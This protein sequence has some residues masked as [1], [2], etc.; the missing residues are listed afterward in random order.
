MGVQLFPLGEKAVLGHL[1]L[2]DLL[3]ILLPQCSQVQ[4]VPGLLRPVL[5]GQIIGPVEGGKQG[6]VL[7]PVGI[8]LAEGRK[9][10]G[11]HRQVWRDQ[12]GVS[13]KDAGAGVGGIP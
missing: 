5:P 12:S 8:L 13:G 4:A 7:Q 3:G 2:V 6:I 10:L 1:D 9:S 11:V